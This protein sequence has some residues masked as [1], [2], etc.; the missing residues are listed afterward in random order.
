M[1]RAQQQDA[2]VSRQRPMVVAHA[3]T[4]VNEGCQA[5]V[6]SAAADGAKSAPSPP[7]GDR[8]YLPMCRRR[9]STPKGGY[10]SRRP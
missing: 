8:Y 6:V 9:Q 4:L 2:L 5:I 10:S 7:S 3:R 1:K